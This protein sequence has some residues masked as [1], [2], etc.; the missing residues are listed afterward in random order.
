L[1]HELRNP[2]APIRNAVEILRMAGD[3]AAAAGEARDMLDRQLAQVIRLVDDLL[4]VSRISRGKLELRIED[5]SLSAVVR[6]AVEVA[7]PHIEARGHALEIDVPAGPVCVRGDSA[8]LGQVLSN[9]LNNAA[10]YTDPGGR[11]TVRIEQGDGEATI[12]VRDTGVGIPPSLLP[13]VFEM[14]TQ[15]DRS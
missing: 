6:G 7:R 3:D 15:A 11:I 1:A 2:L 8:R 12:R 10:K 5:V 4:D 14:F 13:H 9:L